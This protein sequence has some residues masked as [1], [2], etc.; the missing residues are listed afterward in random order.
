VRE[1]LFSEDVLDNG[2]N[3]AAIEIGTDHIVVLRVLERQEAARQP[4]DAVREQISQLIKNEEARALAAARGKQ[5]VADLQAGDATLASIAATESLEVQTTELI[6][7]NVSEPAAAVV[8]AAFAVRVPATDQPVHEGV[9][10]ASGDYIIV[11]LEEVKAGDFSSLPA[12]AQEQLW[13]NLN[14]VHGAAELAAV[15]SNL[16]A[17]ATITIPEQEDR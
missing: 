4:L 5:L 3:S 7:R 2:N 10:S 9:L 1:A 15:L 14:K 8:A 17:Q 16:K 12:M 11:A 6:T 13:S